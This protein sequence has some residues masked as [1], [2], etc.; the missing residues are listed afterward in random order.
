ML[1]TPGYNNLEAYPQIR[2][3]LKRNVSFIL[4][5]PYFEKTRKVAAC[6]LRINVGLYKLLLKAQQKRLWG[7][8]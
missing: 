6:A 1:M 8:A 4:R 7:D 3:L 2:D 5:C